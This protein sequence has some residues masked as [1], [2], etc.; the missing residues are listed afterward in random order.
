MIRL[1]LSLLLPL[2]LS[3]SPLNCSATQF[4][5]PGSANITPGTAKSEEI[6]QK[7]APK[8][9]EQFDKK[10]LIYGAP[11]FIR[12]FKKSHELELWV[13]NAGK[14][15]L[16]K[17]YLICDLSGTLGPKVK[18]GD[19]QAPEGFYSVAADQLNPRSKHHLSFN[20]GFPNDYDLAYQR[21]GSGLMV[22]GKC[23]SLGCFAMT[24]FRIEEIYTIADSALLH[25]QESFPV[26]I[27][28]FRMTEDNLN[29]HSGRWTPFWNNLKEGYDFFQ[30]FSVPPHISVENC[31]YTFSHE[32]YQAEI[33]EPQYQQICL[34]Y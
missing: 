16:F 8:L 6:I 11:I 28:P 27:F 21:T 9:K 14:F 3:F 26:H 32:P 25:G 7:T 10:R 20:L 31:R 2:A 18:E 13:K 24:N 1:F 29:K 23:N 5:I 33:P 30:K 4:I 19:R 34:E 17:T 12:I 22:H 15:H